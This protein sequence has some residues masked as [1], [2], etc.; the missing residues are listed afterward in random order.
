MAGVGTN[1]VTSSSLCTAE[2]FGSEADDRLLKNR[3]GT[4]RNVEEF[5]GLARAGRFLRG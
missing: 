2:W 3:G 1:G 5:R 4:W